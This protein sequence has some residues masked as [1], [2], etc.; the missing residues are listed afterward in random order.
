[1][2]E[3]E[4]WEA[5]AGLLIQDYEISYP[6]GTSI[7][8]K[9]GI[10][11]GMPITWP[12][13]SLINLYC[14]E[15]AVASNHPEGKPMYAETAAT[16]GICGDDLVGFW[17]PGASE[18]YE[19]S[20][21]DLGLVINRKKTMHGQHGGVF[22]EQHF[23]LSWRRGRDLRHRPTFDRLKVEIAAAYGTPAYFPLRDKLIRAEGLAKSFKV[24]P[25]RFSITRRPLISALTKGFSLP[26]GPRF[27]QS[28]YERTDPFYTLGDCISHELPKCRGHIATGLRR[29]VKSTHPI[30][31][32][33]LIESSRP[34]TW[35][36]EIGGHGFDVGRNTRLFSDPCLTTK[37]RAKAIRI[38][39]MQGYADQWTSKAIDEDPT[40]DRVQEAAKKLKRSI[41]HVNRG[42][43]KS[44][45]YIESCIKASTNAHE[46]LDG[47]P[48]FKR[49][50][51][52]RVSIEEVNRSFLQEAL[53]DLSTNIS[54]DKSLKV[55]KL[56]NTNQ[57]IWDAMESFAKKIPSAWYSK[58]P[59]LSPDS[60][61]KRSKRNIG[62]INCK[63][64]T[65]LKKLRATKKVIQ[66]HSQFRAPLISWGKVRP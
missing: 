2:I 8:N 15:K 62:F 30:T 3:L 46:F 47:Q 13:L 26:Q 54:Y 39:S 38:I 25:E 31:W 44:L 20:I 42:S 19:R 61:F 27:R 52:N 57:K 1:L 9:T 51:S 49:H 29:F 22:T 18:E 4:T 56:A 64:F 36:I 5:M 32:K 33:R 11:M 40:Y 41:A 6:D 45:L 10:L 43:R 23:T 66:D 21:R 34:L 24:L 7:I 28:E 14:A 60:L 55:S 12:I 63:T 53:T 58:H 37:H 59:Q 48:V 16:T 65:E 50:R 17:K 35:P